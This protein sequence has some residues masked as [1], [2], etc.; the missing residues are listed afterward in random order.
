MSRK[1][2]IA[3]ACMLLG[4]PLAAY[5]LAQGGAL[6]AIAGLILVLVFVYLAIE[7]IGAANKPKHTI[8]K[9]PDA[10]WNLRDHP[11]DDAKDNKADS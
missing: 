9:S 1:L 3:I 11:A 6:M 4:A 10:A 5:G 2:W 8:E 7:T